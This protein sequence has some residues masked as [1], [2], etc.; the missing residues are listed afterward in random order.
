MSKDN[1][2]SRLAL[3]TP[4][5][6]FLHV[7]QKEF[8]FSLR[9]SVEVLATAKEML[10]GGVPAAVVRPGQI[11]LVVA[12][13]DAPFGPPLAETNKI[14][15]TLTVDSGP[16]EAEAEAV[17][18]R[19]G[20]RR[21]RVLRL[22]EE[23]LEQGGILTQEDLARAL[24]VEA[25]TIR[26]DIQQLKAEGHLVHTRG[27]V[28]GVGR[29]QTHKVR[30]IE[31]WL[32]REGYDKISHWVHHS[33]SSIKRY[34]STF[35][36]IVLLHQDETPVEEIAFLTGSSVRLVKDYLEVYQAA[37]AVPHRREKLEEELARV[38]GRGLDAFPE[39]KGG[40]R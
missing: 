25:R 38:S 11:R 34:I 23:A 32:D 37:L 5:A 24:G 1:V 3:K 7:L 36:R 39:E 15:V 13:L 31:L 30:I 29:G 26:R 33:F 21:G 14:E 17:E 12:R 19:E 9:V 27:R 6:A 40:A 28:K 22:T 16:E 35:Q 18:G 10:L 20:L 8:N 2:Q 4:E